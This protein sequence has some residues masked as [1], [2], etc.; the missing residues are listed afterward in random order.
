MIA[1]PI[2]ETFPFSGHTEFRRRRTARRACARRARRDLR[3]AYLARLAAHRDAVRAACAGA[4]LGLRAASH[5]PAGRAGAAGPAH[6][7]RGPTAPARRYRRRRRLMLGLPLAFAA[8]AVL[9]ALVAA[10]RRSISCCASRRRARASVFPPL[11]LL[12]GLDPQ[13]RDAARARRGGC[14]CCGSRSRALIILA[15]AGPLWNAI[16]GGAGGTGRCWC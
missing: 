9:A 1:D 12:L 4:R 7:A 5:R 16:A 6:A 8:P 3:D 14:C 11:R 2:E 10:R 15:M 13:G